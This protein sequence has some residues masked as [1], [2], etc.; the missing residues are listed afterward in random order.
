MPSL[1]PL[2]SLVRAYLFQTALEIMWLSI[3]TSI[4]CNEIIKYLT[5][6]YLS[7]TR[8]R[9]FAS[10]LLW[11]SKTKGKNIVKL[12]AISQTVNSNYF[13]QIFKFLKI[14]RL[15][16]KIK[17]LRFISLSFFRYSLSVQLIL[18][19]SVTYR[20]VSYLLA[21]NWL[22]CR[23]GAQC[24]ISNTVKPVLRGHRIKRTPSIKRTVAEVPKFISL[25]YFKWNLY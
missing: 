18:E 16:G 10:H 13:W 1:P 9:N 2:S 3:L 24:M 6:P 11:L 19:I 5:I 7:H 8:S 12:L 22:I 25:I 14:A 23:S 21:D 17:K 4:S 20:L 15:L